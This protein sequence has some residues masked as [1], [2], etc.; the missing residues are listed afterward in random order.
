MSNIKRK[1]AQMCPN[2]IIHILF[3]EQAVCR[4]GT[5]GKKVY[6]MSVGNIV[7]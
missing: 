2:K 5:K 4:R 1:N 6:L 3:H 7:M